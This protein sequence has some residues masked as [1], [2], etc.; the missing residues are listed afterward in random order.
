MFIK[1]LKKKVTNIGL[2]NILLLNVRML[3]VISNECYVSISIYIIKITTEQTR[4]RANYV[5]AYMSF[6]VEM[7]CDAYCWFEFI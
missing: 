5:G 3:Y 1:N 6:K 2:K 4:S 7:K